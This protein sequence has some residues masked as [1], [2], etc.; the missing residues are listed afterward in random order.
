MI[1]SAEYADTSWELTVKV[2]QKDGTQ[3][4][5]IKLRVKGDLHIGGLMLKLVEQIGKSF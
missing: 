5:L 1:R 3:P 4:K 2:D